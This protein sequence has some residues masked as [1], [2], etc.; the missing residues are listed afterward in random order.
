[1][2]TN[3]IDLLKQKV[4]A[5]VLEGE[6]EYLSEKSQALSSFFPILLSLFKSKPELVKNLQSQLN[7]RLTDIFAT[8]PDLKQEFLEQVSGTVPTGAIES[9]LN[10][11]ISPTLGFL[12]A[13]AGSSEPSAI[14]HLIERHWSAV[15]SA[16][17]HWATALLSALGVGIAS[18]RTLHQAPEAEPYRAVEEKKKSKFLLPLIAF[19]VLAALLA[20]M[21]KACS[22]KKQTE[23][24]SGVPAQ[25]AT[26][27]P[28]KLQLSTGSTGDLTTCQLYSGNASYIDIL[29]KEIK[30][31]FN[32]NNGCGVETNASYHTEFIDQDAIP[33]VLKLVKGVPNASLT[34]MG[35]QLSIQ[36]ANP[37]DA[38]QLAAK[39]RPLVKNMT[40]MTQ[41]AIAASAPADSTTAIS[42]GNTNAEKAL[43]EINPENIRALD[44][45]TALNMQII[46]FDTGS[47]NIPDANKSILDQAAALIKRASHVQLTV[48]GHTDA[49]GNAA[50]NKA[51]SQKR[52]QAVVDYLVKQGVDPA[53]LQAVGYGSE[54]PVADNATPEGQFKNRRIEFEVLNTDTGVV[55]D[56]DE[57]GIKKQ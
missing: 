17:P 40:V 33:S 30:Q 23:P 31:I 19:I 36:T 11:S 18:G 10:R 46:N 37:A 13:E 42:A 45:A 9:T 50:A 49:V 53:Q 29:Q 34:W 15:S 22:D 2:N 7:P 27:E 16:L 5:I 3:L 56:V 14:A 28:A 39:I 54:Q 25:T 38:E 24:A 57:Q 41:A 6:T 21:F 8:H 52:A 12:E 20:L 26:S 51:L 55:R 32:H 1:M 44:I 4:S 35:D 43:A 48:K 47:S